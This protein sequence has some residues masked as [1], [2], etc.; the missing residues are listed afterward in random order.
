MIASKLCS[1]SAGAEETAKPIFGGSVP[2]TAPGTPISRKI[3]TAMAVNQTTTIAPATTQDAASISVVLAANRDDPGLFQKSA[4][5]VAHSI[6]DFFVARNITGEIVGCAGLHRDSPQLAEIHAVAVLPKCQG[7]G[8]GRLLM[9]ACA[10]RATEGRIPVLWLA[11]IKPGYFSQYGFQP[12]P[13]WELPA[14]VLLR[15]LAQVFEQPAARWLGALFGKHT[16][17][18]RTLQP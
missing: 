7:Q 5:A 3:I 14:S 11:T 18:R 16:F 15:K 13:R 8:I 9:N 6:E 12:I 17:M 4:A 10:R 1:S 2:Q